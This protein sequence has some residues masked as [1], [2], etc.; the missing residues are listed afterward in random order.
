MEQKAEK[1][2]MEAV[3]KAELEA[4]KEKESVELEFK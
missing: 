4:Q 3:K 2:K 1:E